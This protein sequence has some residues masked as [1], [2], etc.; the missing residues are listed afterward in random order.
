MQVDS[1]L[2]INIQH[3]LQKNIDPL[4]SY[5]NELL[6]EPLDIKAHSCAPYIN[7]RTILASQEIDRVN[8]EPTFVNTLQLLRLTNTLN[9]NTEL[10]QTILKQIDVYFLTG[11]VRDE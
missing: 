2:P 6:D 1:I 10:Y 3:Q 4:E 8:L 7:K 5:I 11:R 9:R